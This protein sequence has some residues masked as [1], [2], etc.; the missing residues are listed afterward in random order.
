MVSIRKIGAVVGGALFL[1]ATLGMATGAMKTVTAPS[2]KSVEINTDWIAKAGEPQAQLVVGKNAPCYDCDKASAEVIKSAVEDKLKVTGAGG[3]IEITYGTKNLDD[4]DSDGDGT[5]DNDPAD[6]FTQEIPDADF[7]KAPVAIAAA[8]AQSLPTTNYENDLIRIGTAGADEGLIYDANNDGDLKD[9]S[10]GDDYVLYNAI[11]IHDGREGLIQLAYI[12]IPDATFAPG[13]GQA[14]GDIIKV[15]GTK[16]VI[17]D[18]D[19][20]GQKAELAPKVFARE[21]TGYNTADIK[22]ENA[23][24]IEENKKIIYD[25]QATKLYLYLDNARVDEIALTTPP[26][27][28]FEDVTSK[29][30]ADEFKAYK[31]YALPIDANADGVYEKVKVVIAKKAEVT[32]VKNK[33]EGVLGYNEIRI[34]DDDIGKNGIVLLGPIIELE[35]G[36]TVDIPDTYY[37]LKWTLARKLTVE[38][39]KVSTVSS[40]TKLK[41]T[42][43]PGKDFL[44][45]GKSIVVRTVGG[46]IEITYGTK[47]LD[48]QD[49]DGDGTDDND[50][51]DK[52][53]QEIPDADFTKAP[54]AIAAADAQSLPTTNYE[55]DLIRIGTAGADE[56]LIYDANNDGD[57]KDVSTGDDYVLYNAIYIHDGREGLIQLAY[58]P[59]PD[60]TFAPG[61]GQAKGDI[62]KV[63]GTKYVITDID[64][65]GQKAELAPK[66]FARELTGY[67]TADI[68]AENALVIEENKKII[69]DQQATKL[70]LYLDNARVDEIALTTPPGATFEDVT[71]KITADEFK[72]YKMYALPI[73]ANADGV[74]EKVK[75]VI[76]KKAEVTSV[77]NKEEGVLGYNE[78]RINDDDIGKNGIVL[79]GPIIELERGDTVDIP[80]TYYRLKWTLARKLTVERKKVSTVS[81]GTKLKDTTSPGKDFLAAGKSIVVKAVGGEE[82][83]PVLEIVTEDKADKNMNLILVGGPVA[84]TLV[85]DLV[86]AGKSKVDWYT[87]EGDIEVIKDAFKTGKYAIIVAGKDRD[88]TRA[89]AEAL[90]DAL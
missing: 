46:D 44:A 73:D 19:L 2:G 65:P 30:T 76:A 84:N 50:P 53:T 27:A 18:I 69:Y 62:I 79:L 89:A 10:T 63:R 72:A 70:Y 57:L 47:N 15:R 34:N 80:D 32:S 77:K 20:P 49:S 78:I 83:A 23:L 9:V 16:Y 31:M 22:A 43:S 68:K 85:A 87:S 28:T 38:R 61:G 41:D 64:L 51:A 88:A 6:K 14:K 54:V 39:K 37:R 12:P 7:T 24:V 52:F 66:V 8:D 21:L 35:R 67:N 60:A 36:D 1:G 55:N 71:S 81:S 86:N 40:G 13:G 4:Q 3:D 45:A 59:I 5:D 56:G 33:E 48:D 26:G 29:I 17:T 58:I 90:A 11:Y 75:V 25:Q 82:K 74:Y 42:T